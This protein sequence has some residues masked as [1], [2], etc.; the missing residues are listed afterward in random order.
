AHFSPDY[1]ARTPYSKMLVNSCFTLALVTGLTVADLS[2]TGFNLDWTHVRMPNPLVACETVCAQ[3]EPVPVRTSR[4]PPPHGSGTARSR[5][6]IS[7]YFIAV[8]HSKRG[9][10]IDMQ[11]AQGRELLLRLAAEADVVINNFRPGVLDAHGLSAETLSARNP[12][13]IQC[14]ISGFGQ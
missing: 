1:A 6:G 12:R 5:P 3:P 9:I 8:N 10:G 13:L 4:T 2:Q 11:H 14:S 7:P